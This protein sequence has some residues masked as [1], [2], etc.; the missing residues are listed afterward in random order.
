MAEFKFCKNCGRKVTLNGHLCARCG[1]DLGA[2]EEQNVL[3]DAVTGEVVVGYTMGV[4][5]GS[6]LGVSN[7]V[8]LFTTDRT[9]V[10]KAGGKMGF[11]VA[12]FIGYT[13]QVRSQ[14]ERM[15][16]STQIDE[17]LSENK[18][19]YAI[20]HSEITQLR[21]KLPGGALTSGR[22]TLTTAQGEKVFKIHGS[23]G[24]K[25]DWEFLKS[26]PPKLARKL[27]VES[28]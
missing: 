26:P 8:L 10:A 27:V 2:P 24:R 11:A 28:S 12:G 22:V 14:A 15:A 6:S 1:A 23:L 5:L 19:N 13:L 16:R 20:P 18:K 9:V 7:G 21:V 25:D 3:Q 17:L 4:F